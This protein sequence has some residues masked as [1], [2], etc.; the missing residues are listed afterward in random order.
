MN[1]ISFMKQCL[2]CNSINSTN[3]L[4]ILT[5]VSWH[6]RHSTWP[7]RTL[8]TS[9]LTRP[10]LTSSWPLPARSLVPP[11]RVWCRGLWRD[12]HPLM[13]RKKKIVKWSRTFSISDPIIWALLTERYLKPVFVNQNCLKFVLKEI[14]WNY[15]TL[16]F[17]AAKMVTNYC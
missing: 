12:I 15:L 1:S 10:S 3:F 5:S 6:S 11:Y 4:G 14:T 8:W 17:L 9:P 2:N 13:S 7:G 16:S